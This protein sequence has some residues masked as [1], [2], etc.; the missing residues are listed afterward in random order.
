MS[1]VYHKIC[2]MCP[3]SLSKESLLLCELS[4]SCGIHRSIRLTWKVFSK[5]TKRHIQQ[6][7]SDCMCVWVC[8]TVWIVRNYRTTACRPVAPSWSQTKERRSP[9]LPLKRAQSHKK[10]K[11]TA[12]L[13]FLFIITP[14][15][16]QSVWLLLL[17]LRWFIPLAGTTAVSYK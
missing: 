11:S 12:N 7:M 16:V 6:V 15:K 3:V 13:S 1:T 9:Q 8:S 17:C 2:D 4:E 14:F 10:H 5:Q